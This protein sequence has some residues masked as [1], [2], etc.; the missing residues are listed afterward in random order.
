M[1]LKLSDAL[2]GFDLAEFVELDCG[3]FDIRIR[4]AAMHN[5]EFRS[6]VAKQALAA[7][8]KSL[9]VQKGTLTGS[10]EQDVELFVQHVIDG[11]GERPLVDDDGEVV[12]ASQEN[13]RYLFTS[14]REG[15]V[16]FG[17]IQTAAV[18]D[19]LFAVTEDDLKNS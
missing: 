12:E 9:V 13:L 19:T 10:L 1:S 15:K 14:S 6:A 7:K 5:E 18:D 16:L 2:S 11:W 3:K 17:K 8:K 4:Q